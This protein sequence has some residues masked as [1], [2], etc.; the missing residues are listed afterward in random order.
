M[1]EHAHTR[2]AIRL[3]LSQAR[4]PNYLRDWV[5]GGV[6]GAVTTFAVVSGVAGV[7]LSS[8]VVIVVGLAAN[9]LA[10]GFSMAASNYSGTKTEI[11]G[12]AMLIQ[13]NG[14]GRAFLHVAVE[15]CRLR[16]ARSG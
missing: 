14:L 15:F 4:R 2:E 10:D 9:L 8:R 3:R 11:D 16:G 7:R 5:Y 1:A 13:I 6:D 12:H